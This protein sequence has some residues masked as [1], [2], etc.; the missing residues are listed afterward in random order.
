MS[1]SECKRGE[2][3][4][5]KAPKETP[6]VNQKIDSTFNLIVEVKLARFWS[7]SAKFRP[8]TTLYQMIQH[9]YQPY[10]PIHHPYRSIPGLFPTYQLILYSFM[11]YIKN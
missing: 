2:G 1:E 3:E 8:V 5:F 9:D 11:W 10:R 7:L 4:G 6:V